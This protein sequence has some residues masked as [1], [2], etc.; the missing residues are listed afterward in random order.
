[1]GVDEESAIKMSAW[2]FTKKAFVWA[3]GPSGM[4]VADMLAGFS[5]PVIVFQSGNGEAGAPGGQAADTE[6][7]VSV[8]R[9]EEILRIEGHFGQF[10]I[11][12]REKDGGVT[13]WE[14]GLVLILRGNRSPETKGNGISLPETN[15]L[16]IDAL[17]ALASSG[18]G[19]G[20][21]ESLGVWLD[22]GEGLPDRALSERALRAVLRMKTNGKPDCFV[23]ARHVPLWGLEGQSL[24]DDLRE[25]G[26][27][28]L[29]LGAERP[30]LKAADGRVEIEVQD[31]TISDQAVRLQVDRLLVVGQP[32]PPAGAGEIAKCVGDP[33]DIEGFL[34][35]D[36]VHLYPSRSFRKGI[37]YVGPCKGEQAEEE[38][39]EEVGAILPEVLA[40]IASGEIKAPEGIRIDSGHC[41]S[42]L[43]CYRVCPHHALDI[44]Q[45]PTPV[46]VDPA[47][48]GCGLCAALC[49]GNA[50]ELVQRPGRQILG[51]LEDADAGAKDTPHTV[52]FCCSRSGLGP[53][54]NGGEDALSDSDQ[55]S[56]I[57][58]PCACSVSE[59][60]LLAAFLRGAEEVVV[61]GCHP[62]NCVSQRGSA[63][64]EKRTQRVARYL[65]ATGRDP[66]D[67]IRFIAVAPNETHRLSHILS[68]LDQ[69]PSGPSMG[70]VAVSSEGETS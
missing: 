69:D 24:Y 28:F 5:I 25:K 61:V 48:Y 35:K 53:A 70:P 31:R 6:G 51:E 17:E 34:Q 38:L 59:E 7:L 21:P 63:V 8:V 3:V 27:R 2:P 62:D 29:R 20:V 39:V 4:A 37:Y 60:M 64:G 23:L 67:C 33:L 11:R 22:P 46:P 19:N 43:T 66:G 40:P 65:A 10:R 41:V 30:G 9:G 13:E 56:F 14:A 47:C 55:T 15:V 50:I 54:G 1:M 36:N 26:V 52:L 42:C 16:T 12:V 45:G 58:V 49:P 68:H 44:S 18:G 32:S 57:E